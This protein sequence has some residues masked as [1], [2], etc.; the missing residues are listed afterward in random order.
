[1]NP[2]LNKVK[3]LNDL[4][5]R[6]SSALVPFQELC[7]YLSEILDTNIYLFYPSGKIFGFATA[8]SSRCPYN[9]EAL[10]KNEM[11]ANYICMLSETDSAVYNIHEGYPL[12]TCSGVSHCIFQERY[13]GILPIFLGGAKVAG[14]LLIRY[15]SPFDEAEEIL[16]DYA[17]LVIAFELVRQRQERIERQAND[18]VSARIAIRSLSFTERKIAQALVRELGNQEQVMVL[19]TFAESLFVTRSIVSSALRK[20]E[21]A[22]T[23]CTK[24]LGVKGTY[25]RLL[26]SALED[27]LKKAALSPFPPEA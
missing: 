13:Y 15:S 1:M 16:C 25:I 17:S 20:L 19:S 23:I 14:M 26:N 6:S 18:I 21:S 24:S 7:T 3:Q 22:G 12:C 11:P 2:I 8:A 27:E 10:Q 5:R 9:E 4:L